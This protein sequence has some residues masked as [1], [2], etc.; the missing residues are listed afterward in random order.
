VEVDR[1][2][3][4]WHQTCRRTRA[5]LS[6]ISG[7]RPRPGGQ[8]SYDRTLSRFTSL[9]LV[10]SAHMTKRRTLC[11]NLTRTA[12]C[13]PFRDDRM[14]SDIDDYS[15][16]LL[17]KSIAVAFKTCLAKSSKRNETRKTQNS[18]IEKNL[19]RLSWRPRLYSARSRAFDWRGLR[20]PTSVG[21]MPQVAHWSSVG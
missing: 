21:T 2:Q 15:R 5:L 17:T 13:T 20:I 18:C 8:P 7:S 4:R 6:H 16:P 10:K 3:P 11:S 12:A 19:G 14:S 9:S 1:A